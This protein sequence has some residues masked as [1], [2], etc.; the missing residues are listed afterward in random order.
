MIFCPF[1]RLNPWGVRSAQIMCFIMSI[2][3]SLFLLSTSSLSPIHVFNSYASNR[4]GESYHVL[5]FVKWLIIAFKLLDI[6]PVLVAVIYFWQ[7]WSSF[8][9]SRY[10]ISHTYILPNTESIRDAS[11]FCLHEVSTIGWTGSCWCMHFC[12]DCECLYQVCSIFLTCFIRLV[13]SG[14]MLWVD[15]VELD[16]NSLWGHEKT[17]PSSCSHRN[18]VI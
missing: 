2:I 1:R 5:V 15:A 9:V 12:L 16:S 7:P 17:G 8:L 6:L 4:W 14:V 11:P 10:Y 13:F 3:Y 18:M